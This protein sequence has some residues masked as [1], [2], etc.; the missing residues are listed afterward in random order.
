MILQRLVNLSSFEYDTDRF[1]NRNNLINFI[2]KH[3]L[4]GIELLNPLSRDRNVIP[5]EIIKGVH[6]RY[7]PAWLDFWRGDEEALIKQFENVENINSYYEGSGREDIIDYLKR[8]VEAANNIGAHYAVFHVSHAQ[9]EH[10]FNYKFSY[11][12]IE[13]IDASAEFVNEIFKGLNTNIKLLFENLWWPGLTML[14]RNMADR[15]LSRVDYKNKG[16]M[17]D[18]G[19]LMNTNLTLGN[20][21][22]AIDYVVNTVKNL[23]ELGKMIKGLHLNFSLSGQYVTDNVINKKFYPGDLTPAKMNDSIYKHITSI[24]MHDPFTDNYARKIIREIEPEY[25]IYEFVSNSLEELEDYIE[26]QN[27]ALFGKEALG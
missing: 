9:L 2:D 8:E 12:D 26:I 24:D 27:T 18:T 14:D 5:D 7:Y 3:N 25:L 20:E 4:N 6:L 16:F 13:V 22:E 17:L 10:V 21:I 15:L 23:G 11:S 1:N 19:H